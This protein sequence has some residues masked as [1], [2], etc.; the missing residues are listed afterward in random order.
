M[1][2]LTT[3]AEAELEA[4]GLLSPDSD[5]EGMIGKAVL[6]LVQTLARQGHSGFSARL[7]LDVFQRVA[8]F[9]PLG[10]LTNDPGEWM[11]VADG[12]RGPLFQSRRQSSAFSDDNL[13]T[14]YDIDERLP[15]WWW[16]RLFGR[17]RR[18]SLLP[19]AKGGT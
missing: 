12:P 8:A 19:P 2:S 18:R 11:H 10:P 9:K 13:R 7:T 3:H 14:W 17:V 5:Y 6:E 1:S 16:R 4:S 15:W